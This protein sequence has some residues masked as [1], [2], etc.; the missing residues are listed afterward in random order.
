MT[1]T[2]GAPRRT[3][4]FLLST[5]ADSGHL[6]RILD[7]AHGLA[8]RGHRA[9]VHTDA[10]AAAEVKAAS[11]E[12]VPYAAFTDLPM[13]MRTQM[14]RRPRW[15][16]EGLYGF[17]QFG[18][19]IG[20]AGV[21]LAQ[22]L[23]PILRRERVDCVVYD[24]FNF[25][26]G[27]AAERAGIP[28]ASAG[29]LG[30]ALTP[31]E[32]PL[33]FG[34]V[35]PFDLL[36]RVPPLVNAALTRVAPLRARRAELGLPPARARASDL[37]AA[38]VSRDLHVVMAHR[39]LLGDLPLRDRQ[40]FAGPT[41]FNAPAEPGG[42]ALRVEPGT[43]VVSTT[44]TGKDGGLFRRVLEAVATLGIPVLATAASAEDVPAGLGAHVRIER[45]IPHDAV[46]PQ[47]RALITHG[48]WGTVG[49]AMIHGLPMLVIPLFG[50]QHLN[51]A[52]VERAGIG[53][54]LPLAKATP[55][56][57]RAALRALLADDGARARAQRTAQ[58]IRELRTEP[59]AASALEQLALGGEPARPA[60]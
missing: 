19:Q 53:L 51:A 58:E 42:E 15:V 20:L 17:S 57:I 14:A 1:W 54:R 11:A 22:E 55:D 30:T 21:E 46:F 59:V 18:R 45:Y 39:G 47:A 31:D 56:A 49:R 44:T 3:A 40:V 7:L 41:R 9:L 43:V 29:N 24:F 60:A 38:A 8:R 4:T 27:W 37:V 52:L 2:D 12:L 50:D 23:E 32:L 16:P 35:P 5:P 34:V 10:S 26:A 6:L 25:G 28:S 48:G 13:R 33:L 36:A